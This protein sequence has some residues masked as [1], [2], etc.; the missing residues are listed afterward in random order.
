MT[1][2]QVIKYLKKEELNIQ[3]ANAAL[4][5]CDLVFNAY[6]NFHGVHGLNYSPIFCYI[7]Y[8]HLSTYFQ[9]IPQKLIDKVAKKV[10]LDYSKDPKSLIDKIKKRKDL[11]KQ[12]D[13]IWQ[14]YRKKK[15]TL[16]DKELLKIYQRLVKISR[17]WWHYAVIAED[18]G[19]IINLEVVPKFAERHNLDLKKAR[20]IINI[21]SHPK[22]Q[23]I[24]NIERK[25]F[26]N[27]CLYIL[28]NKKLE[29]YLKKNNFTKLSK[30]KKLNQKIKTYRERN[31]WSKTDFY[32][33]RK[34]TPESLL[35]EIS[36]EIS[37]N[38]KS[39]ILKEF[40][41]IDRN[42]KKISKQKSRLLSTLKLTRE[43]KKDIRFS[44][45]TTDWF[46]QRKVGMMKQLYYLLSFLEDIVKKCNLKYHDLAIYTVDEL[47]DFLAKKKRINKK[48]VKNRNKGVFFV[49]EKGKK[50]R[51]F[52]GKEGKKMFKIAT[53]VEKQKEIKGQIACTGGIRKIKGKVRIV[54]NPAKD[55]FDKGEILVTSMT[56]IEFIP[57][58]RKAKAVITN[59]GGLV[60][61]AAIVSRELN[62]PCIIGTKIATKILKNRDLVEVDAI[63]G[64]VKILKKHEK[65]N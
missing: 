53:Y 33:A 29:N 20:E 39:L 15:N 48:D 51:M 47:K 7:F 30:D 26:L 61:H 65:E 21:L 58:M 16:S 54:Y 8:K 50:T 10:Y 43:E 38:K 34:I 23:S 24:F 52:Y 40:K 46:D 2:K 64:A 22:T 45:L 1:E 36:S 27:I 57:L 6:I 59:E 35:K 17:K 56:R 55:K 18:K 12:L 49:Y 14:N 32:K 11:E 4:F 3:S 31:F 19:E 25:D 60:C 62:I 5:A 13:K 41:D 28:R 63:K 37:M 44:Q 42:F 9:F